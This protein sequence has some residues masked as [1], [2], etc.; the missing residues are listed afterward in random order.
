MSTPATMPAMSVT[1]K[2]IMRI[3]AIQFSSDEVIASMAVVAADDVLL[4]SYDDVAFNRT[5]TALSLCSAVA[6]HLSGLPGLREAD[7][8]DEF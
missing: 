1:A 7:V 3:S 4:G 6:T 2:K 5:T 8:V